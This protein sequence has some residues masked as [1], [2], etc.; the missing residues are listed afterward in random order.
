M[1]PKRSRGVAKKSAASQESAR[2]AERE[3]MFRNLVRCAL[4]QCHTWDVD[5]EALYV[6]LVDD[7]GP[8]RASAL[9]DAE[10]AR[11]E[12]EP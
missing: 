1:T 5:H 6:G 10:R 8:A 11:Q 12:R 2:L 3:A 9:A 4:F 7:L